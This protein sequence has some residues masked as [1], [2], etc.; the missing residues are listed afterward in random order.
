MISIF[1]PTQLYYVDFQLV[2]RFLSL[3]VTVVFLMYTN[4]P[5]CSN[6]DSNQE[7]SREQ[8]RKLSG[9]NTNSNWGN[10]GEKIWIYLRY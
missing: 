4:K 3:D 1:F 10:I 8:Y 7:A 6:S 5:V 2:N 9:R